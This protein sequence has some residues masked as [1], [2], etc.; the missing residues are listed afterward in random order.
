MHIQF[1]TLEKSHHRLEEVYLGDEI[2]LGILRGILYLFTLCRVLL[3][4]TVVDATMT[5]R[6]NVRT[7]CVCI[8]K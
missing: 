8:W 3:P 5:T 4:D 6:S 7:S 1:Q 2:L